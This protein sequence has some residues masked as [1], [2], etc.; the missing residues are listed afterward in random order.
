MQVFVVGRTT[1]ETDAGNVWEVMGIFASEPEAL[2]ACRPGEW[3]G[4]ATVGERF[5]E[6]TVEWPNA[7]YPDSAQRS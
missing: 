5:E 3:I 6:A 4:P 7:Y 1:A 2:A